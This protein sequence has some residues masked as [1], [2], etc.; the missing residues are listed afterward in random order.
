M[1]ALHMLCW[2]AIKCNYHS[3]LARN[4]WQ[5]AF[6]VSDE[7][8]HSSSLV[9]SGRQQISCRYDYFETPAWF[10][11]FDCMSLPVY[12]EFVTWP[13][14]LNFHIWIFH[15]CYALKCRIISMNYV[16]VHIAMVKNNTM[17]DADKWSSLSIHVN[18]S[19]SVKFSE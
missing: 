18:N 15:F 11:F 13:I 8:L 19:Q 7:L 16:I 6:G 17:N 3:M 14:F 10:L 5:M 12:N 9:E 2:R 4:Y 1:S